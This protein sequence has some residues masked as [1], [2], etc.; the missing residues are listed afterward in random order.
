MYAI[1]SYYEFVLLK[2]KGNDIW[3][4]IL[5]P[6]KKA[7]PGV[8]FVFG[9]GKLAAEIIEVVEE[10][11]RLVRFE[12]EGIFEQ[13]LDQIGNVPLPPYITKKVD[14]AE[15]YQTVYSKIKGSAAAPTA[16]L[17]FIV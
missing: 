11:N 14:D 9:E 12:Y 10:G 3:E 16:G 13:I 2:N 17:H 15:R 4:V 7:K 5:K 1:R 6:G 8:R